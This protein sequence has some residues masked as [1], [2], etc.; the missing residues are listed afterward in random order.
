MQW[1]LASQRATLQSDLALSQIT[2]LVPSTGMLEGFRLKG[3]VS[4][5]S[6]ANKKPF[7]T[8]KNHHH[9]FALDQ[10]RELKELDPL[11]MPNIER[12]Y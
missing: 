6:G 1:S 7:L 11:S 9:L 4:S 12:S 3:L 10:R 5:R 2:A 8:S